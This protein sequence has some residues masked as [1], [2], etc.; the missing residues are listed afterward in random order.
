MKPF[1][2]TL[3]GIGSPKRIFTEIIALMV[4]NSVEIH[5]ATI[6]TEGSEPEALIGDLIPTAK[7][8][9]PVTLEQLFAL[10]SEI[11]DAIEG[12]EA[13]EKKSDKARAK[14]EKKAAALPT[15][16]ARTGGNDGPDGEAGP[17]GDSGSNTG[18][19]GNAGDSGSNTE[20]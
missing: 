1:T 4:A 6:T 5:R 14:K 17:V 15:P 10:T 2:L 7:T 18:D 3:T 20:H 19:A 16:E 12:F 9:E 11:K 8:G 13:Y